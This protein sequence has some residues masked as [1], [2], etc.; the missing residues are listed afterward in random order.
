M[1]EI[2]FQAG[3][4]A[5]VASMARIAV[6]PAKRADSNAQT[7]PFIGKP[8]NR[9]YGSTK[10]NARTGLLAGRTL[11]VERWLDNSVTH[12]MRQELSAEEDFR[13]FSRKR[14]GKLHCR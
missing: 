13:R 11:V 6:K 14:E 9:V 4:T 12:S 7:S 1:R 8:S 5:L 2:Y 3:T 10:R